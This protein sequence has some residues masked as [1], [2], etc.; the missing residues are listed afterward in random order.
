MRATLQLYEFLTG[1]SLYFLVQFGRLK[2]IHSMIPNK[3]KLEYYF[4]SNSCFSV[5]SCKI[6]NCH[7]KVHDKLKLRYSLRSKI[8]TKEPGTEGDRYPPMRVSTHTME[9]SRSQLIHAL[10]EIKLRKE[11]EVRVSPLFTI[12]IPSTLKDLLANHIQGKRNKY[13]LFDCRCN[14]K[15]ANFVTIPTTLFLFAKHI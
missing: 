13:K 14:D 10:L 6:E 8:L 12:Y 1:T 3:L 5:L 11:V 7:L 4:H 15:R 9:R 2:K